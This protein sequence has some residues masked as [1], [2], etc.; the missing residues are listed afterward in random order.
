MEIKKKMAAA[1]L[2]IILN[3]DRKLCVVKIKAPHV[4]NMTQRKS[5]TFR[6]TGCTML[7]LSLALFLTNLQYFL[8]DIVGIFVTRSTE[9]HLVNS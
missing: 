8:S 4:C 6:L 9:A 7:P 1:F 5:F 3:Q 2:N